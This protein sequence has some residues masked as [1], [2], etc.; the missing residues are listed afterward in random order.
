MRIQ[1]LQL[2]IPV[3]AVLAILWHIGL[4]SRVRGWLMAPISDLRVL[5]D[6]LHVGLA[7]DSC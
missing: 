5:T 1:H 7:V 2:T 4:M 3:R 6:N